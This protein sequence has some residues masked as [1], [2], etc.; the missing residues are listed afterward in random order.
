MSYSSSH[1]AIKIFTG[2]IPFKESKSSEVVMRIIRGERPGRPSHPTFTVNL[3]KLT[4]RCWAGAA[5]DRPKMEDVLEEL[6]A[7]FGFTQQIVRL[8]YLRRNSGKFPN[9]L[10]MIS[11]ESPGATGT[12]ITKIWDESNSCSSLVPPPEGVRH[13]DFVKMS[14]SRIYEGSSSG[15]QSGSGMVLSLFL[16]RSH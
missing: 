14:I 8:T 2:D 13:G 12:P 15:K 3:W 16:F 1:R 6:S 10:P 11:E 7:F 5:E 9:T 4:Q